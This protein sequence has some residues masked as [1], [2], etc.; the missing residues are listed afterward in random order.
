[1]IMKAT[2]RQHLRSTGSSDSRPSLFFPPISSSSSSSSSQSSSFTG[3]AMLYWNKVF[4]IVYGVC[5]ELW[6]WAGEYYFHTKSWGCRFLNNWKFIPRH[7]TSHTDEEE[8]IFPHL[9]PDGN[10]DYLPFFIL[11]FVLFP[12]FSLRLPQCLLSKWYP[13]PSLEYS[14]L[15]SIFSLIFIRN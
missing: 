15:L 11:G 6:L 9:F 1:M 3:A 2:F 10:P 8:N 14:T 7:S 5:T 12:P 4:S 13:Y